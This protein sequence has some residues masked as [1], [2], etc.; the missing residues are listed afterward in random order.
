MEIRKIGPQPEDNFFIMPNA[1]IRDRRLSYRARGLMA[2]IVSHESGFHVSSD[3]LAGG[4]K[5]GIKAIRTAMNE[6]VECDYMRRIRSQEPS[7]QWRTDIDVY[8]W[9]DAPPARMDPVR[10]TDVDD[11]TP[12]DEPFPPVGGSSDGSV[13][14]PPTQNRE[15]VMVHVGEDHLEDHSISPSL[16]VEVPPTDVT[17]QPT[18]APTEPDSPA[19][20]KFGNKP[21]SVVHLR[22]L[23]DAGVTEEAVPGWETAWVTATSFDWPQW[24]QMEAEQYPGEHLT[25]HLLQSRDRG[26]PVRPGTWLRFFIEDR[27]RRIAEM[28]MQR[29]QQ[30]RRQED[31]AERE[32][33]Q[34]RALPP[35]RTEFDPTGAPQ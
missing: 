26:W 12:T 20:P 27:G 28:T 21:L 23:R 9:G 25:M 13:D 15:A 31:P 33:R 2:V 24:A 35:L 3:E 7:G 34:T 14:R 1:V 5:E 11:T 10:D 6:L 30:A 22:Q 18:S 19:I 29:A 4:G 32:A 8:I 17:P 16:V